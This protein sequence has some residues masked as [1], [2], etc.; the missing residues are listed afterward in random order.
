MRFYFPN[1]EEIVLKS[2][3]KLEEIDF[4]ILP[5]L[6]ILKV[7]KLPQ[8]V[9][10]SSMFKN[11]HNLEELRII[12]CGMK[13]MR[14]VNTSTNDEVFFN[15]KTSFLESRASTLNKIMDALRDHNINLIG[16]RGM[17][18][19]GK[20]TLLKQVAQ[21]AKQQQLFTR[22]VLYGLEYLPLEEAWSLFKK[23]AGDSMEE[24]L[25][26]QPI[27]IQVVEECEGL[28]LQLVMTLN[29][30]SYFV[31]CWAMVIFHWISCYEYGMGL[32]LFDRIDSLEQARNRLLE[33][34]EILNASGLLLDSH[35]ERASSLLFVDAD[36][37]FVRMH[38]VVREVAR[39]IASKDPHPF[40]VREDVG[41]EEWSETE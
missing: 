30:C 29:H 6:K 23:T 16:V 39:A 36:N 40:V 22:Q 20:T 38:G 27:A 9:L 10:S 7:E 33:L 18:G 32:D 35:E 12:D 1:L 4:G 31:G 13:D 37:K 5:K 28:Q 11:F 25:E 15:E 14:G 19:V 8:L 24:N 3:P 21:Q 26:L 2:L 17:A 34:V 41:L